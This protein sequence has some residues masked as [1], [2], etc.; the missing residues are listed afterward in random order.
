M[1]IDQNVKIYFDKNAEDD[2][3]VPI[4]LSKL[5]ENIPTEKVT[6]P[7][8]RNPKRLD[9][10]LF[11]NILTRDGADK[12]EDALYAIVD[13]ADKTSDVENETE[14]GL[15]PH[16]DVNTVLKAVPYIF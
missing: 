10:Y 1:L 16:H 14:N 9:K 4:D 12:L 3:M 11:D 2:A 7:W 5:L 6:D 8:V 13:D 15:V